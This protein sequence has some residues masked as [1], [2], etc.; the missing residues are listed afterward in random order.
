M[1][2]LIKKERCLFTRYNDSSYYNQYFRA[3]YI[4]IIRKQIRVY[5]YEDT[6]TNLHP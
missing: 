3:N 2:T 1:S 4:D 6:I 5:D